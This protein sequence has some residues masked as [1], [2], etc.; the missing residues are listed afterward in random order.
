MGELGIIVKGSFFV[1]VEKV[2]HMSGWVIGLIVAIPFLFIVG[3]IYNSIKEQHSLEK[4]L[5][6]VLAERKR[7]QQ[8]PKDHPDYIYVKPYDDED[9]DAAQPQSQ[10]QGKSQEPK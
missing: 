7:R 9:D 4:T 10:S 6:K 2:L 3:V 8:L 1:K 5:P